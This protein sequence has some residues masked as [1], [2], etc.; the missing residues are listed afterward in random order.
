LEDCEEREAAASSEVTRDIS[1][2]S[3]KPHQ[4]G[5]ALHE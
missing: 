2:T 4:A 5:R 3:G 1:G